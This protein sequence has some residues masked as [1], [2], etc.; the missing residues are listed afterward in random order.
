MIVRNNKTTKDN[1]RNIQSKWINQCIGNKNVFQRQNS[2]ANHLLAS[3][4]QG[5][6]VDPD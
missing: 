6:V 5:V 2:I 4:G 3:I 1:F